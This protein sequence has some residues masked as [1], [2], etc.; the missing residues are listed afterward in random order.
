MFVPVFRVGSIE[1]L[2]IGTKQHKAYFIEPYPSTFY[3]HFG[4][5][6]YFRNDEEKLQV[7]IFGYAR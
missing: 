4:L 5:H 6:P 7:F 1:E 2:K 3:S